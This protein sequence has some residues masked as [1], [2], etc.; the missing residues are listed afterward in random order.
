MKTALAGREV[1][2]ALIVVSRRPE[3][4]CRQISAL[5]EIGDWSL[6][7]RPVERIEDLYVDTADR[8][9]GARKIA[10]RIRRVDGRELLALKAPGSG[11][12]SS[13]RLAV[14][15]VEIEGPYSPSSAS[16][17]LRSLI[18]LGVPLARRTASRLWKK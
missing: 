12:R 13:R 8:R 9:L 17:A 3:L 2:S 15:R 4:L 1:E 11:S 6:A 18:D 10:L 14:P 16:R 5:R 7:R